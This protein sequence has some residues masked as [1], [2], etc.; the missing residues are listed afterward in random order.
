MREFALRHHEVVQLMVRAL[1]H[2]THE[3]KLLEFC[4]LV[5]V[6]AGDNKLHA[7]GQVLSLGVPAMP[8]NQ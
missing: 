8:A 3:A 6:G 5:G 2:D 4:H 1:D 7:V